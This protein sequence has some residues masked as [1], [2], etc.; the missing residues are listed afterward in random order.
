MC[1]FQ[2]VS[3]LAKHLSLEK[4]TRSPERHTVIDLAK[5]GYRSAL[6][7]SVGVL[8]TLNT[9]TLS[10]DYPIA[11]AKEG[12]ALRAVKKVYWFSDKQKS[13]LLA[14]FCIGQTTG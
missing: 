10:R 4:C 7:E 1:I 12:W 5:M 6:E 11:A 9:M 8:L 14:K 3:V 13:H 2:W